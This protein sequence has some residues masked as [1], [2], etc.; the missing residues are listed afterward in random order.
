MNCF[1]VPELNT[2][3]MLGKDWLKQFG[4]LCAL[5]QGIQ[6]LEILTLR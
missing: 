6:G 2:N 1:V 4:I 5:I 3:N